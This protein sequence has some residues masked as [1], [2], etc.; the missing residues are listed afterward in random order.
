MK[1]IDRQLFEGT[2]G[3]TAHV[4]AFLSDGR[5]RMLL[6]AGGPVS[7]RIGVHHRPEPMRF[8]SRSFPSYV[9][10][11]ASASGSTCLDPP[12]GKPVVGRAVGRG[13]RLGPEPGS[14]KPCWRESHGE[15][16]FRPGVVKSPNGGKTVAHVFARVGGKIQIWLAPS[17]GPGALSV[18]ERRWTSTC[19]TV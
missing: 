7:R 2:H 10:P 9:A 8:S 3:I 19:T 16:R 17:M 12:A 18:R 5:R 4:W 11:S 13:D 1:H 14:G 15:R 6:G